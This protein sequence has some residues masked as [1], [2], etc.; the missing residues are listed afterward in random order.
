MRDFTDDEIR[1]L[2][3]MIY[4]FRQD[5]ILELY[6]KHQYSYALTTITTISG[7]GKP[8][9][10]PRTSLLDKVKTFFSGFKPIK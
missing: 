3:K 1:C 7:G 5:E 8:H 2:K 10:E 6:N 9:I 4:K